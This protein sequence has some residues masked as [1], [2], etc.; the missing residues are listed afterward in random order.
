MELFFVVNMCISTITTW[1]ATLRSMLWKA[2]IL[3]YWS[4][5]ICTSEAVGDSI[6]DDEWDAA[7]IYLVFVFRK[8]IFLCLWIYAAESVWLLTTLLWETPNAHT[9]WIW[10]HHASVYWK[11]HSS[12]ELSF[13]TLKYY[14]EWPLLNLAWQSGNK[15]PRPKTSR[16]SYKTIAPEEVLFLQQWF[17][18]ELILSILFGPSV[19]VPSMVDS[20]LGNALNPIF[21]QVS[22]FH[23]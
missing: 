7:Y 3:Y 15:P 5:W 20:A 2:S 22:I 17:H 10:I 19:N 12:H 16:G 11:M 8:V 21:H 23:Q 4:G 18:L 6:T 13:F 1:D 9:Q 14:C